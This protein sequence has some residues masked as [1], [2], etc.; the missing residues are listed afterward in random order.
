MEEITIKRNFNNLETI[1]IVSIILILG[2]FWFLFEP[3]SFLHKYYRG[4]KFDNQI[5][6]IALGF[7]S[8]YIGFIGIIG[9]FLIFFS[10]KPALILN[11]KGII[12]NSKIF[13][14]EEIIYWED[15][16]SIQMKS[17]ETTVI[18]HEKYIYIY[19]KKP[20]KLLEN[21]NS[22]MKVFIKMNM[23]LNGA[24]KIISLRALDGEPKFNYDL[25]RNAFKLATTAV[26]KNGLGLVFPSEKPL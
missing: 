14:K 24:S 6:I 7:I 17:V 20:E 25:I 23:K 13:K 26:S 11:E 21:K 9:F 16:E 19:Y 8:F 12:N 2:G 15:I 22:I 5:F 1:I 3:E 10:K 18:S 4:I